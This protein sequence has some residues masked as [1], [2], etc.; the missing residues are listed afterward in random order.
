[1]V[2]Y[3]RARA[4]ALGVESKGGIATRAVR[5]VILSIGLLF[6]RGASLGDFQL[7]EPAV[8]VLAALCRSSPIFQ[9]IFHV[10]SALNARHALNSRSRRNSRATRSTFP[11][12]FP[13][14]DSHREQPR[15]TAPSR[16][17]TEQGARRDHRR[18][19]LRLCLRPGRPLLQGRRPVGIASPASCTSTSAATTSATSSSRARSTSTPQ[20]RQGPRRG[21]LGRPEQHDQ[22]LRGRPQE[23]RRAQV[24]RGMTHDGLGKYLKEKITKA[25]GPTDD[26]VQILK[27]TQHRRRRLLPAGRLRAGDQVVR[28][29]GAGGGLRLRQ[30]HPGRSSPREDYWN[31]RF[32]KA[33]PAD[34]RRRHQVAGRRDDHAPRAGAPVLRP[35][36]RRCSTPR[37]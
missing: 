20:G 18:R 17:Q 1:M 3:T 11:Q 21:D 6:A 25:P 15:P 10:R 12:T 2:S 37:S 5:V 30:L 9:R 33:G 4:E 22:V 23:P 27:D 35:R 32:I 24:Y 26:I 8:Y 7:L 31:N 34:R 16:Y 19:Q 29:A 36:R 28:R 14:E 13:S